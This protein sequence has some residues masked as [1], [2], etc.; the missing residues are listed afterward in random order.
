MALAATLVVYAALQLLMATRVL[1][2]YW[3]QIASLAGITAISALGLNLV[4]GYTGQFSLGHAAFYGIGAYASAL[5]TRWLGPSL[6]ALLVGMAAGAVLA[7]VL[8]FL[9]GLPILRL[10]SDYL[11]IAT[12]GFG[13]IVKVLLDN[14]DK[15]VP[16]MGGS[17][18]M[19][20][21]PRLTTF[22]LVFV[23]ALVGVLLLR[24]LVFSS[25]GRALVSVREDELAAEAVGV[26]TTKYKT[27]GFTIGCVY[28]GIAGA[29][30]AHLYAYLNPF[31]FDFLKS[32][33]VLLV[34][35]L[36]GLGSISGTL[37]AA[38]AWTFLLEGLRV[39]LPAAVQDWRMVI[40]PLVMVV[41]MLFRPAGIF[42]GTEFRFLRPRDPGRGR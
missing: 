16:A 29:L 42:G 25:A 8:A 39:V 4:Y 1:N 9:V 14:S 34:V 17:A 11:A 37:V 19:C 12:L 26:N 18:G 27:L 21:I 23:T 30:Y 5:V 32:I 10:R 20:G 38:V 33:D 13:I 6:P 41:F 28:A 3:Q 7:G 40:Y 22:W 31:N 35:V 24:N 15:V 2:P 36:G